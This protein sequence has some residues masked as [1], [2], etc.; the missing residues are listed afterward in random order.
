[1]PDCKSGAEPGFCLPNRVLVIGLWRLPEFIFRLENRSG[2]AGVYLNVSNLPL[3]P[4]TTISRHFYRALRVACFR[5][6][7]RLLIVSY[8]LFSIRPAMPVILDNLAHRYAPEQHFRLV[9]SHGGKEHVHFEIQKSMKED[10]QEGKDSRVKVVFDDLVCL[11]EHLNI[12]QHLPE[13]VLLNH[14]TPVRSMFQMN[15]RVPDYPP[16]RV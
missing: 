11:N 13:E 3:K 7:A 9:H 10:A 6:V 4:T 8:L 16:P 5:T 1:V 2:L 15:D 14:S 12:Q